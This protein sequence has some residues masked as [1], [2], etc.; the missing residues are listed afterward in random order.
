MLKVPAKS[1]L[2]KIFTL[3]K[4]SKR[5]TCS[6]RAGEETVGK[7]TVGKAVT[8]DTREAGQ[9]KTLNVARLQANEKQN[10]KPAASRVKGEGS[11]DEHKNR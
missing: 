8:D 11:N 2:L 10:S 5:L 6:V 7:A 4:T 3:I 9:V 1:F